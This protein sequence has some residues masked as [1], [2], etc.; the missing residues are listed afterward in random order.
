M[1]GNSFDFSSPVVPLTTTQA[2]GDSICVY[3][4]LTADGTDQYITSPNY[5]SPYY[6]YI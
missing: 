6:R 3:N 4:E 5:P 2:Y 1:L